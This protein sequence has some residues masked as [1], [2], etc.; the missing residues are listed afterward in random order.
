IVT[1]NVGVVLQHPRI[2]DLDLTLIA[3]T[4]QRILLFENRGGLSATNMGHLNVF[5]NFFGSTS[6][7]DDKEN[8]N[9]IGPITTFGTLIIN[10]DFFD[11][12]SIGRVRWKPEYLFL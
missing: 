9:T 8:D 4:G 5:T 3:P 1:M 7:G 11:L 2:S 12:R 6:A 10:Y